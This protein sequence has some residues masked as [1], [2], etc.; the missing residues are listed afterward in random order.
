MDGR[1]SNGAWFCALL[2]RLSELCLTLCVP[3]QSPNVQ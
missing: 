3:V 1:D 2:C